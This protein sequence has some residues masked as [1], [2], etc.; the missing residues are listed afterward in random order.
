MFIIYLYLIYNVRE[1]FIVDTITS[2]HPNDIWFR[3]TMTCVKKYFSNIIKIVMLVYQLLNMN[4]QS[5]KYFTFSKA[6]F[7]IVKIVSNGSY[8]RKPLRNRK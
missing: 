3:F 2:S 4:R 6:L 1:T 5:Y 8:T 7:E